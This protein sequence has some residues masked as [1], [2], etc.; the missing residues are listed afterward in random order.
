MHLLHREW[1]DILKTHCLKEDVPELMREELN[2]RFVC[3]KHFK[4]GTPGRLDAY[5]GLRWLLTEY[6]GPGWRMESDKRIPKPYGGGTAEI[7]P[8]PLH[9]AKWRR[10]LDPNDDELPKKEAEYAK[11]SEI[12]PIKREEVSPGTVD[13]IATSCNLVLHSGSD[14]QIEEL[15]HMIFSSVF[16]T[17]IAVLVAGATV[18][19][20]RAHLPPNFGARA[21]LKGVLEVFDTMKVTVDIKKLAYLAN[22]SKKTVERARNELEQ[23]R[24]M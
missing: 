24:H 1:L 10:K 15:R 8:K 11:S 4:P 18:S 13:L 3:L 20:A 6:C 2:P 9:I 16:G 19:S 14:T 23:V 5:T 22:V 17:E 21:L 7:R 12:E